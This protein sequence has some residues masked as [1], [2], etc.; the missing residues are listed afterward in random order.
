MNDFDCIAFS[1]TL[2][3]V[4]PPGVISSSVMRMRVIYVPVMENVSLFSINVLAIHTHI[5]TY[6]HAHTRAH[7]HIH[8]HAHARTGIF[9]LNI[10]FTTFIF[11]IFVCHLQRLQLYLS[12]NVP[13]TLYT[14]F[15]KINFNLRSIK[16]IK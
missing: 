2:R 5:H 11:N 13:C 7:T 15:V 3:V 10:E 16:I 6:T 14:L 12:K 1:C 4:S 8:T 9:I